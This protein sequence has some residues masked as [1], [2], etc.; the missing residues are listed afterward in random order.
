MVARYGLSSMGSAVKNLTS[1]L[2]KAFSPQYSRDAMLADKSVAGVFDMMMAKVA[3]KDRAMTRWAQATLGDHKYSK[4][5]VRTEISKLDGRQ[6]ELLALRV[7]L[8]RNVMDISLAHENNQL[9]QGEDPNNPTAKVVKGLMLFMR[10]SELASRKQVILATYKTATDKGADF[11][12]AMDQVVDVANQTLFDYSPEAKGVLLSSG[13]AR[14]LTQFQTFRI[15]ALFHVA[16]LAKQTILGVSEE[17]RQALGDV[18][19]REV[20]KAATTELIGVMGMSGM[21]AGAIGMPLAPLVF[22]LLD[23]VLGDDDEPVDSEM[24]F[25]QWLDENFGETAGALAAHGIPSLLGMNLSRRIGLADVAWWNMDAPEHLHS[26]SLAAYVATQHLGPT[27]SVF[28]GFFRGYDDIMNKGE[29]LRGLEA[30]TPKPVRDLLKT[31]RIAEDGLMTR[32]GKKLIEDEEIGAG[33]LVLMALGVNP[34]TTARAQERE[35]AMNTIGTKFSERRGQLIREMVK[36]IERGDGIDEAA[37]TINTFAQKAPLLAIDGSE[38]M[39]AYK[40]RLKGEA[41]VPSKRDLLLKE[42]YGL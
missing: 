40:T 37:G 10:H 6:K 2:A 31:A 16:T 15:N 23:M 14:V 1:G 26:E 32:A 34:L 42:M 18:K 36:A 39:T 29:V 7:A 5:E 21:L 25:K 41:M 8:A 27:Y 11:F 19:A 30:M 17:T 33:D 3:P 12:D 22:K 35:R 9:V 24:T 13:A 28:A 20:R 4:D 38:I